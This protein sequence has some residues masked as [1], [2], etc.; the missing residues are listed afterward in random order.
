[1]FIA[2]DHWSCSKPLASATLSMT[3][4]QKDSCKIAYCFSVS[5]R[6]C[7]FG[8][9]GPLHVFQHFINGVDVG[10]SQHKGLDLSLGSSS[11]GCS[12]SSPTPIP[13]WALQLCPASSFNDTYGKREGQFSSNSCG[14]RSPRVHRRGMGLVLYSSP[15]YHYHRDICLGFCG[16]RLSPPIPFLLLLQGPRPRYGTWW[17]HKQNLSMALCGTAGYSHQAFPH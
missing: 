16:K 17:Q 5:W 14:A 4:P 13:G 1:M 12:A 7:S 11:V 3:D 10:V 15:D 8:S 2:I 9:V 6:F